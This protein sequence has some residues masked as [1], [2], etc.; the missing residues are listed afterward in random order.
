MATPYVPSKCILLIDDNVLTRE[1]LSLLLA[2]AGYRVAA[3]ANGE[4]AMQRL[5]ACGKADLIV[6]DLSMPVMDGRDFR[7][8]QKQDEKL[9][10]IPVV[11]YSGAAD[12]DEA[13]G[14]L[15]AAACL[16]KP[17]DAN[18]LLEVIRRCCP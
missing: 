6:L 16:H 14:A 2:G 7:N 3:A 11:V 18:H 15:G 10:S 12:L 5:H 17:I 13:A 8:R 1:R 9:A 4:E